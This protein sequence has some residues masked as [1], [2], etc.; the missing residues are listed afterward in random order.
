VGNK[1]NAYTSLVGKSKGKRLFGKLGVGETLKQFVKKHTGKAGTG[2]IWFRTNRWW[3]VM[4][5]VI[6]ICVP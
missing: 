3:N 2:I 4:K 1:R 6:N 5:T